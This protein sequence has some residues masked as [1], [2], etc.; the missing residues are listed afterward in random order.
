MN[1]MT[2]DALDNRRGAGQVSNHEFGTMLKM[3]P[4]DGMEQLLDQKLNG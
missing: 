3:L 4:N 2:H 1:S